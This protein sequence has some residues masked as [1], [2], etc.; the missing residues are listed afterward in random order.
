MKRGDFVSVALPGDFG[1]PRPALIVQSNHFDSLGTITILLVSSTLIDTPLIRVNVYPSAGNGLKKH[2]QIMIDKM[3]T[4]RKNKLGAVF[5][6]I[7]DDTMLAV[8]RALAVFLA[9]L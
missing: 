8:S 3:M 2:S 7:D 5:G 6:E 9:I 1:K 4:V